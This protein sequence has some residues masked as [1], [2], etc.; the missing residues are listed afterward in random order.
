MALGVALGINFSAP[1]EASHVNGH[2][3]N[4]TPADKQVNF[5]SWKLNVTPV[6]IQKVKVANTISS[7]IE[8]NYHLYPSVDPEKNFKFAEGETDGTLSLG[9]EG[10]P[11][12]IGA[13][14]LVFGPK[15]EAGQ[16]KGRL[17]L[18]A[19]LAGE[20]DV[21]ETVN[22]DLVGEGIPNPDEGDVKITVDPLDHDFGKE[23]T[24][25]K[26][27]VTNNTGRSLEA[28]YEITGDPNFYMKMPGDEHEVVLSSVSL[29]ESGE[30]VVRFKLEPKGRKTG[31]LKITV[32]EKNEDKTLVAEKTVQLSGGE[33]VEG[34]GD[35]DNREEDEEGERG[36]ITLRFLN[37]LG[38]VETIPDLV[39]NI[40]VGIFGLLGAVAVGMIV[41][42][43]VLYLIAGGND[44]SVEK[45]KTVLTS[46]ITGL[47]IV[48][49]SL[50][51]VD[52][53][54]FLLSGE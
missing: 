18:V 54:F 10:G 52:L 53:V 40:L 17:I 27:I 21:L 51:I 6:E 12:N 41:Y 4:V 45:A 2:V 34:D 43:G 28:I 22:I 36:S 25:Q 8:V 33:A 37:P 7:P 49:L 44:K 50:A 23:G 19:H 16:K 15:G 24:E 38:S 42:G 31:V 47:V 26:F 35:K 20:A 29:N 32:R 3:V 46:A 14:N 48:L 39:R 1:A 30:V 13:V 5:G 11:N 9:I